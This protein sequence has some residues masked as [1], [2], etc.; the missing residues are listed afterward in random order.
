ML[1]VGGNSIV[2]F[3]SQIFFSFFSPNNYFKFI[4]IFSIIFWFVFKIIFSKYFKILFPNTYSKKTALRQF[5]K[6]VPHEWLSYSI[7]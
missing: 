3:F 6:G 7:I 1:I 4:F 2:R 5:F